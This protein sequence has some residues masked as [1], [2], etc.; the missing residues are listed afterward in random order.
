M[1]LEIAEAE[2]PVTG[3]LGPLKDDETYPERRERHAGDTLTVEGQ[4]RQPDKD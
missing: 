3:E 2:I 4:P 1:P